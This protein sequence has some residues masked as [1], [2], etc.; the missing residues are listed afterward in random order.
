[1]S[2]IVLKSVSIKME[3]EKQFMKL[4]VKNFNKF[5]LDWKKEEKR[6][7]N[8]LPNSVRAIFC[9]PSNCGKTNAL[10]TLLTRPNGLR[11]E[12]IYI[13]SKSLNQPK[14]KFLEKVLQSVNYIKYFPSNEH[15]E[16][17]QP[18]EARPDSII[19]FDDVAYDKQD[20]IRKFFSMGRHKLIDC[21]KKSAAVTGKL[22]LVTAKHLAG[23]EQEN[24]R[25]SLNQLKLISLANLMV[26]AISFIRSKNYSIAGTDI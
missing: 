13:Y 8:L 5:T 25:R 12:N 10:L 3:F 1:M 23:N 9:G 22:I 18:N 4:A 20:N 6:H 17:V 21:T 7:E 2:F 16:V 19:V 11:F 15:R 14:Y 24:V 26:S